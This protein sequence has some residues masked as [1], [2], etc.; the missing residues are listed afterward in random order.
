MTQKEDTVLC[1]YC[2]SDN[3]IKKKKAGY[4]IM[5]SI[6]LLG[7]PLPFFKKS[8]YCFD[9]EKEWGIKDK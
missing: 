4:A 8:Y 9:C 1:P 2:H 7:L 6:L 3:V 5:L